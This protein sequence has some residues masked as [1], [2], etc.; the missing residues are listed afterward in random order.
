MGPGRKSSVL[1]TF[2]GPAY[3]VLSA[4]KAFAFGFNAKHRSISRF[5]FKVS[6]ATAAQTGPLLEHEGSSGGVTG[7]G[8]SLSLG[9]QSVG[10]SSHKKI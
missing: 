10:G 1:Q 4:G 9:K 7:P 2:A 6:S 3:C 8:S 5:L